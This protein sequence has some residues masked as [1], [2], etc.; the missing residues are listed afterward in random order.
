MLPLFIWNL[1]AL[2]GDVVLLYPATYACDA[3]FALWYTV[4]VLIKCFTNTELAGL[5]S[6]IEPAH[7]WS[8]SVPKENINLISPVD[9]AKSSPSIYVN[10]V[11]LSASL[12]YAL[13]WVVVNVTP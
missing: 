11:L 6:C 1:T 13:K 9:C 3:K 10:A 5:K 7:D 4:H 12:L 2:M 8:L